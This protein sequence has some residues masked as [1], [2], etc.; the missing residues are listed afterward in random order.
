MWQ[1]PT[2]VKDNLAPSDSS[3]ERKQVV[4]QISMLYSAVYFDRSQLTMTAAASTALCIQSEDIVQRGVKIR[5]PVTVS[6]SPSV[7]PGLK[8]TSS[9]CPV[10]P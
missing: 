2:L 6:I 3:W 9:Y 4:L 5:L 7:A 1:T 10:G 8:N